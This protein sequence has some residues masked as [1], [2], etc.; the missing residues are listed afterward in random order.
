[1]IQLEEA[2]PIWTALTP[3]QQQTL[4]QTA[5]L[6]HAAQGTVLHHGAAD[7]VGLFLVE[8]GQ[9]RAYFVSDTGREITL[10]RL[11]ER[12]MCLFS[13][14]CMVNSLQFD[15]MISTEKDSSF[16]VIPVATYQALMQ[17]NIAVANYT[18]E[19]MATRFSEVMWLV[20]QVLFH[21]QDSRLAGFLLEESNIEQS[22]T[23]ELTQE[24]IAGH[25]G[26]AREV[27]TRLLKYLQSEGLVQVFRGG[28][29]L[30]NRKG[31]QQIAEK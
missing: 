22:D 16:W 8:S 10:Y 7:C 25:L 23:L 20:D 30:L 13:A 5:V 19:L 18:N 21:S 3:Q 2:F 26:T 12:D 14:S 31:L 29:R 4:R 17:Q 1:M 24:K 11:F 15:V 6:R 9:L 27:V 28:V